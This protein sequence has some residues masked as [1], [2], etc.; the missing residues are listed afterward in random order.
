MNKLSSQDRASLIRLA[1]SLP[2]GSERRRSI[3]AGLSLLAGLPVISDAEG[4]EVA[5]RFK[6][7]TGA[8]RPSAAKKLR[9]DWGAKN[10]KFWPAWIA[11]KAAFWDWFEQ[12]SEVLRSVIEKYQKTPGN[13]MLMP[14]DDGLGDMARTITY[15]GKALYSQALSDPGILPGLSISRHPRGDQRVWS[16]GKIP[17]LLKLVQNGGM[18]YTMQQYEGVPAGPPPRGWSNDPAKFKAWAE[19]TQR[20]KEDYLDRIL[21]GETL[22]GMRS[23]LPEQYR[24][25][26]APIHG[27]VAADTKYWVIIWNRVFG[28]EPGGVQV[29]YRP[30]AYWNPDQKSLLKADYEDALQD[31]KAIFSRFGTSLDDKASSGTSVA[32]AVAKNLRVKKSNFSV[33]LGKVV[34]ILI[35]ITGDLKKD[36]AALFNGWNSL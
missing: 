2:K 25:L 1:S 18:G 12:K 15:Q 35:P 14:S 10:G 28:L 8:Q 31:T 5:E 20:E 33:P 36:S 17:G 21:L 29:T 9:E 23:E 34:K 22:G 32:I 24:N 6:G 30:T 11:Y 3:L 27:K 13:R 7:L 16:P 19:F 4:W 26:G